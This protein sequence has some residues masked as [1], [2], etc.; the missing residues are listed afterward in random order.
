M[1]EAEIDYQ[2]LLALAN[3]LQSRWREL[4]AF[5][6]DAA[7]GFL[8]VGRAANDER[9]FI[10]GL[11][12]SNGLDPLDFVDDVQ[13]GYETIFSE[14]FCTSGIHQAT[15][16]DV[17]RRNA[18]QGENFRELGNQ[19][20]VALYTF[21]SEYFRREYVVAKRGLA[22]TENDPDVVREALRL[23]ASFDL[24]GDISYIRND[25]VH[26][27]AVSTRRNAARCKLI[28]WFPEGAQIILGP[29]QVRTL[30]LGVLRF[31]NDVYAESL[32][33]SP[34]IRV[35]RRELRRDPG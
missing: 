7:A 21:W 34:G 24:W 18:P 20:V 5:Y 29:A 8:L 32:P 27:H 28:K 35:P 30:L 23:H 2:R 22:P 9:E 17:R 16:A 25:I 31:H 6:L 4:Q 19:L 14:P 1:A 26:C 3:E 33:P 13:W 12:S 15:L 10:L 11:T